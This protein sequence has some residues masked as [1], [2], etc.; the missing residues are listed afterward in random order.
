MSAASVVLCGVRSQP[1]VETAR[2]LAQAA[3]LAGLD[4]SLSE[5]PGPGSGYGGVLVHVRMGQEVR[6]SVVPE[7]SAE[8]LIGFEPLEA[9]RA[10][11]FLAPGGFVVLNEQPVPTWRMRARLAPPPRDAAARLEALPARVVG[12]RAEALV[13]RVDG[14]PLYGLALLGLAAPLLPVSRAAFEAAL[15]AGDAMDA[16]A[17][18]NAFGR[19]VRLFEALP[20]RLAAP[21]ADVQ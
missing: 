8:V 5:A 16:E 21:D 7:A 4:V 14:A 10:A 17:R 9:L 19:G 1:V 6:S 11:R 2:L 18:R 15:A 3:L 13:R 12:V 20:H